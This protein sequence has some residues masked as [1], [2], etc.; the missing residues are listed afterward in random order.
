[1][2]IG[3]IGLSSAKQ[4]RE[5]VAPAVC[6]PSIVRAGLCCPLTRA[7]IVGGLARSMAP[8]VPRW[9]CGAGGEGPAEWGRWNATRGKTGRRSAPD[10][11]PGRLRAR[12][13]LARG[14]REGEEAAAGAGLAAAMQAGA[15]F[16]GAGGLLV[17]AARFVKKTRGIGYL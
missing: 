10:G 17:Y 2:G 16:A 6:T 13:E 14:E 1:M 4:R 9:W 5:S 7:V 3:L 12:E 11:R 8:V 15:S